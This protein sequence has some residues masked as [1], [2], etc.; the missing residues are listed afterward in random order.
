MSLKKELDGIFDNDFFDKISSN[1]KD[2]EYKYRK[3]E[4]NNMFYSFIQI[5]SFDKLN[6]TK[7]IYEIRTVKEQIM[8]VDYYHRLL[9]QCKK[10]V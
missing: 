7:E 5:I 10:I 2:F 8:G 1:N 4:M 6:C 3:S 9:L